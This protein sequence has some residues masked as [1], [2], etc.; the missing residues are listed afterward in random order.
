MCEQS[1]LSGS[2][3]SSPYVIARRSR[4]LILV[5]ADELVREEKYD[6]I[7]GKF[8]FFVFFSVILLLVVNRLH[9]GVYRLSFERAFDC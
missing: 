7:L 6:D 4:V 8:C 3:Y 9:F 5:R 2:S 1:S